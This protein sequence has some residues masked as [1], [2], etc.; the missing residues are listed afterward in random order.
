MNRGQNVYTVKNGENP[1]DVALFA[2]LNINNH[3]KKSNV[4]L[5]EVLDRQKDLPV[6]DKALCEHIVSATLDHLFSI[7]EILSAYSKTP[8][9]KLNPT[10]REILRLSVCQLLYMDR[11]P[12]PAVI[13]EGTE[14]AKMHGLTG[15]SG[16]VNG[17]LRNISRDNE[18]LKGTEDGR[19]TRLT[20]V[21]K[22]GYIRWS[23]PRWLYT[24]FVED[25]G[26][27]AAEGIFE[28]WLC[29]RKTSVRVNRSK[30]IPEEE[31]IRS[32]A[33][34]GITAEKISTD[35][36]V[37]E[38]SGLSG[39]GVGALR[40]FREGLIT[41]QDLSAALLTTYCPPEKGSYV[42]DLCAAPGGKSLSYADCL[43][44]TGTVDA[45]DI[46]EEKVA[47]IKENVTRCGFKNIRTSVMDATVL[48]RES[49][50]KADIVIADLPCS[51]LGVVAKKPDI[52]KNISPESIT[53]LKELQLSI[54]EN[55]VRYV[56]PGG[57]LC[58][59]TCTVTREENEEN[60]EVLSE[61]YGLKPLVIR[62]IMPGPH[63]DGFFISVFKK[64]K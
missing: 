20:K 31:I 27:S 35:P 61:K 54:L 8:V 28:S 48:D 2:L 9:E 51:G 23:V 5:R 62:R 56:K 12:A 29:L 26:L 39:M 33:E 7:D 55:A 52:K 21:M 4:F 41:V 24:K 40:A 6:R 3:G 36:P 10:I 47:L 49:I 22:E 13:N 64:R 43:E 32:I 1:R 46:S 38:L 57:R 45:R 17:V 14:L 37:Y 11:V 60:A 42:I 19:E 25:F 34:D 44:G 58:Y 50:G 63:S 59:S 30:G 15:L 18:K 53:G 16:Y